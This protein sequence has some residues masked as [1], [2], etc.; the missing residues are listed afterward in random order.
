MPLTETVTGAD[1]RTPDEVRDAILLCGLIARST[2]RVRTGIG[3]A[4]QDV[5]VSVRGGNRV[6]IKGVPRA[7]YAVKLVH[8]EGIRQTNLLALRDRMHKRGL[9]EPEKI[10]MH[11]KD[12][13]DLFSGTDLV[14]VKKSLANGGRV[15]GVAIR[16]VAGLAQHPTQPGITFLDEL[17]GRIR[18]IAC[19]DEP[20]IVIDSAR[21]PEFSGVHRIR[22]RI[23]KRLRIGEKD[24]FFLVWGP[25]ADCRTAADEIRIRFGDAT[26]GVPK[27][28]RQPLLGGYTTFER[29]LPGPDRMYPDTDLPPTMVTPKRI[30]KIRSQLKP[31]PWDRIARYSSWRVP[32]ET[33]HFLIRKGGAEIVDAVVEKTGVDGLVAAIEIGQRAKALK[34]AGIPVGRLDAGK[35]TEIF[36]LYTDGKIF[37]ESIPAV[38]SIMAREPGLAPSDACAA[39]AIK[40]VDGKIWQREV[41]SLLDEV[42]GLAGE[43]G[44]IKALCMITGKATKMLEGKAPAKEIAAYLKEKFGEMGS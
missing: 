7:D 21:L 43:K 6:E 15:F 37:R 29:I 4:R 9:S 2:L 40:P 44:D 24:D 16:G 5:N 32:L 8:N 35:W 34:R 1:L 18:V 3:A 38:A 30:E 41:D 17:S 22:E 19:L 31:A 25:Q 27:E 36:D 42:S 26:Q 12:L 11:T 23:K 20:P 14:F 28:T 39:A 13:S 33:S 10:R